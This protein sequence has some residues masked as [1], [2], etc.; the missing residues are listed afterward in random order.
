MADQDTK[1][2]IEEMDVTNFKKKSDKNPLTLWYQKEDSWQ[3]AK[4]FEFNG[5]KHLSEVLLKDYIN[6]SRF[7]TSHG[8]SRTEDLI[9]QLFLVV[10]MEYLYGSLRLM[11]RII[12]MI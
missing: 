5:K 2:T 12:I 1:K 6:I 10:R 11:D 7:L 4:E 8:H 3:L 9:I